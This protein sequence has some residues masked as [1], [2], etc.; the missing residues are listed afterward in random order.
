MQRI[1]PT[2]S[3]FA[4]IADKAIEA[5]VLKSAA[6]AMS[7]VLHFYA[8]GD[9]RDRR[10]GSPICRACDNSAPLSHIDVSMPRKS[11]RQSARCGEFWPMFNLN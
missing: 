3:C 7:A 11:D 9:R 2:R 8:I 6:L 5:E 10:Q 4:E 1:P